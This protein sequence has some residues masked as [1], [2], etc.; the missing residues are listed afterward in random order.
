[1]SQ[2]GPERKGDH[3]KVRHQVATLCM[4]GCLLL[5]VLFAPVGRWGWQA[6]V[7]RQPVQ[8]G[9]LEAEVPRKWMVAG[10]ETRL[11]TWEPCLTSLCM[12]PSVSMSFVWMG[13]QTCSQDI[14]MHSTASVFQQ[15]GLA[16][17][18][19]KE[20]RYAAATFA[21]IEAKRSNRSDVVDGCFNSSTCI[22]GNFEGPEKDLIDFYRIAA[23]VRHNP[24]Q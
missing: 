11:E 7:R 22:L 9:D 13:G 21:C 5:L 24:E 18:E 1:V 3:R 16:N 23:T 15:Q 4:L 2:I 12:S 19:T 10:K 8:V 20:I 17:P 6:I 14:V